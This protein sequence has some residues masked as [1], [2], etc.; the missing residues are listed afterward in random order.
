M[1]A[2]AK[3]SPA[4]SHASDFNGR[5]ARRSLAGGASPR[6]ARLAEVDIEPEQHRDVTEAARRHPSRRRSAAIEVGRQ[7]LG[8]ERQTDAPPD[9]QFA[10][11]ERPEDG[12]P[13]LALEA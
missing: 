10:A 5:P 2:T 4:S 8:L 9:A 13:A 1:R 7:V 6:S 3:R 11:D 12:H